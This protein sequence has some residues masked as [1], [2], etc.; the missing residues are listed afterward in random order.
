MGLHIFLS[1]KRVSTFAELASGRRSEFTDHDRIGIS[2]GSIPSISTVF[3]RVE[4]TVVLSPVYLD[5]VY[6]RISFPALDL[7]GFA[8]P[9]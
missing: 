1:F 4:S 9:W 6:Q 2:Y 8:L 3:F 7:T 5:L